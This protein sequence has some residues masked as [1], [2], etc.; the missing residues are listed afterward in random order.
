MDNVNRLEHLTDCDRI[1]YQIRKDFK[2][3][4]THLISDNYFRSISDVPPAP[5]PECLPILSALEQN[6][7]EYLTSLTKLEVNSIL[8]MF[9]QPD[10]YVDEND[11]SNQLTPRTPPTANTLNLTHRLAH[12]LVKNT[13][14]DQP[15]G[16]RLIE[17][18][19]TSG[20]EQESPRA[21][22]SQAMQMLESQSTT[23]STICRPTLVNIVDPG[24]LVTNIITTMSP[25]TQVPVLPVRFV[26]TT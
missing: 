1:M 5:Y 24:T 9:E 8:R 18:T 12:N 25:Q 4:E 16:F 26:S 15:A 3:L 10:M 6:S 19:L 23:G 21:T 11:L 13:Q 22:H 14:V 7:P 20:R 2:K 17:W